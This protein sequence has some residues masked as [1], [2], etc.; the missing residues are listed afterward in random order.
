[1]IIIVQFDIVHLV[2]DNVENFGFLHHWIIVMVARCGIVLVV[3]VG[4]VVIV[5]DI[6]VVFVVVL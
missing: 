6:V 1:M 2:V 3:G 5:I 4:V